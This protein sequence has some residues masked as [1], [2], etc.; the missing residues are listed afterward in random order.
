M[1]GYLAYTFASTYDFP[2]FAK[3]IASGN[4][5]FEIGLESEG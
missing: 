3:R 2:A 1:P 5:K 4:Y